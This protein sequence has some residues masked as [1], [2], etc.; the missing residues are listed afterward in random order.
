MKF[1]KKLIT[2]LFLLFIFS[3]LLK[4]I[5]NYQK[6]LVFYQTYKMEYEKE[7]NYNRYLKT[8]IIKK[9]SDVEIEKTIR[10]KLNLLKENEIAII[11]PSPSPSSPAPTPTLKVNWERWRQVFFSY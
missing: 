11:L 4:N 2:L 1:I 8:E 10:N 3:Y 7:K 6:K 9:K 5:I